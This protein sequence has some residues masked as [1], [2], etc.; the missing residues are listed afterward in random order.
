[1]DLALAN[2]I[3]QAAIKRDSSLS[4]FH[5]AGGAGTE[6][7]EVPARAMNR[8]PQ[9]SKVQVPARRRRVATPLRAVTGRNC[10]LVPHSHPIGVG[11]ARERTARALVDP[12][13][14]LS[15]KLH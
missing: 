2:E 1:M 3:V 9:M 13:F 11:A 5:K 6:G 4:A 12:A 7:S 8:A 10:G 15:A 14:N